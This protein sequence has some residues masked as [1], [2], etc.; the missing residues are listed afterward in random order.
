MHTLWG[1]V[2]I[3]LAW[4]LGCLTLIALA[5]FGIGNLLQRRKVPLYSG[6][7]DEIVGHELIHL[8]DGHLLE[9]DPVSGWFRIWTI[10]YG[11][12]K[13]GIPSVPGLPSRRASKPSC[14]FR[15][16]RD[17]DDWPESAGRCVIWVGGDRVL[18]ADTDTGDYSYW[19][20]GRNPRRGEPPFTVVAGEQGSRSWRGDHPIS[21][22]RGRLIESDPGTGEYA[23]T[24]SSG[25]P[26][27]HQLSVQVG[28]AST[29]LLQGMRVAWLGADR[30]VAWRRT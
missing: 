20:Y 10:E 13:P 9:R 3:E 18:M 22:G 26:P 23:L 14:N 4:I 2:M 19:T 24:S 17:G 7:W 15:M 1:K 11:A 12:A 29:M 25:Y 6:N 5:T 16:L 8:G 28:P 30:L 21:I 27:H